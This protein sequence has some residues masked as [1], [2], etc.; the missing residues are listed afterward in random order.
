MIGLLWNIVLAFVWAA[1]TEDFSA[2]NTLWGFF[3]GFLILFFLRSVM[4]AGSYTTRVIRGLELAVVF[5]WDL[6]L[7][8]LN[9]AWHVV[10][11]AHLHRPGII[12]IPLDAATDAEIT[13]LANIISLTPGTLSLHIS[14]DKK[15]LYL[16]ALNIPEP[17]KTRETIKR[18]IERRL[19]M[20]MR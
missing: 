7:A 10:T 13:I 2:R 16:H 11:P 20:V 12:A 15:T 8:N 4:G 18:R 14:P 9:V 6:L 19:L 17:E 3:I 1:L 5:L